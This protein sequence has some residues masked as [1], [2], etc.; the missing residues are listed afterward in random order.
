MTNSTDRVRGNEIA[1]YNRAP[2]GDLS[3]VGYFPTGSLNI[4]LPQLGSGPA[5]TAQIFQIG[6]LGCCHLWWPLRMALVRLIR[7]F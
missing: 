2:D 7:S 1:M 5:P 6:L 4:V 3:F